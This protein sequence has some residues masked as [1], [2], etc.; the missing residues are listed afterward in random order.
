MKRVSDAD[1]RLLKIFAT[2]AECKGFAAAQAELNLSAPSISNYIAA[3]EQR[4][5]VRLCTRGRAGFA[6]TDKGAT[7]YREAQKLFAA[8]DE[9]AANAGAVKGRLTGT[10]R[11]G[12]VDCMVTDPHSPVI[13]AVRR[14]S[15]RDHDVQLDISIAAPASLQR[16]VLEKRLHIAIA[17]FPSEISALPAEPLYDEV[18]S[19][20]CGLGHPFFQKPDVSLA[21]IRA[22]RVI[23]RSYWRYAD[24]SRLGI[25]RE[26][27]SVDFMEAQATLILSG[28]YVG[29]LPEHYA[30]AWVA[31]GKMRRLLPERLTYVSPFSLIQRRGTGEVQVV[32]QFISDLRECL[33]ASSAPSL[34]ASFARSRRAAGGDIR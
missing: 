26:A 33:S 20:Y 7:I 16:G 15:A 30:A 21:D 13:E 14:F 29:Y 6:L 24:L 22:S 2:V 18:N 27:A 11:I 19:F 31:E 9:F 12:L 23:A 1:L 8:A 34:A 25:E 3:L 28:A 5:G 4:L 17:C 32:R 10:L